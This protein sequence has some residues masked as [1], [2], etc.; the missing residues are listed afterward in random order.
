MW[1]PFFLLLITF[2]FILFLCF[3]EG[4]KFKEKCNAPKIYFTFSFFFYFLFQVPLLKKYIYTKKRRKL[5][6]SSF[7]IFAVLLK[8]NYVFL[9]HEKCEKLYI[10][11][12]LKCS[13]VGN[14]KKSLIQPGVTFFFIFLGFVRAFKWW[15]FACF[16]CGWKNMFF[17]FLWQLRSLY[18]KSTNILMTTF[19]H[20]FHRVTYICNFLY[21][22]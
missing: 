4:N 16:F 21:Y 10:P 7:Q 17:C 1:F 20:I 11:Y 6:L 19:H 9:S 15:R 12:T 3:W 18:I 14:K 13:I 5:K 22:R 2:H 8:L